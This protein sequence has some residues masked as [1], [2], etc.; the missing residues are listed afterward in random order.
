[1]TATLNAAAAIAN[2]YVDELRR[3]T[4]P[5]RVRSPAAPH[6][7]R[8]AARADQGTIWPKAQVALEESGISQGAL[9][10]EPK[11]A[12]E[13]YARLRAGHGCRVKLQTLRRMLAEN[14]PE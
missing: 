13:S 8:A 3:M 9:K 1:M 4:M 11:S 7:L 10:V 5:T 2:A 14:T 6:V 12:A